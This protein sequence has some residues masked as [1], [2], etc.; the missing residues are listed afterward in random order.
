MSGE[1][2]CFLV[3]WLDPHAQIVW[4]YQLIFYTVDHSLEMYDIKNRRVFL[5]RCHY[6]SVKL[7]HLYVGSIITV[8]SRQLSIVEYAD[9]FTKN[10]MEQ[11]RGK[12]IAVVQ[13]SGFKNLGKIVHA[14][15]RSGFLIDKIKMVNVGGGNGYPGGPLPA[16]KVVGM[17]LVAPDAVAKF[18]DLLGSLTSHFGNC[19]TG[20][21]GQNVDKE[22]NF[23]FSPS[24]MNGK[25][26]EAKGKSTLCLIKPHAVLAGHAGMIIDLIGQN[27]NIT[28]LEMFV[29]PRPN[30]MEFYEVYKGVVA[31]YSSMVEELIS[32]SV[33]AIEVSDPDGQCPVEPFRELCGPP[34]PEIAR[35]LRPDSLRA[36]FG[37]DKVK[38]AVHCTDL[39]ED[40][41]LEVTYFF[42]LLQS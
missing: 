16:G 5:K 14:I 9:E 25:C 10:T 11:Q 17:E 40:G 31:E 32:G 3:D 30:A 33:I 28:A 4:K 26:Y 23:F 1:R 12:T 27:Y 22:F 24:A 36:K 34:D 8:Y 15:T 42:D 29:L 18:K 21:D 39:E 2:Y 6:P 41:P 38:S 20:S 7:E 37:I 35:V 13:P 19:V